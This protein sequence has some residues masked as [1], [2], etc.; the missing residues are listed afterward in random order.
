MANSH[1]YVLSERSCRAKN[2]LIKN[3][4]TGFRLHACGKEQTSHS[5]GWNQL[6]N[7]ICDI[8]QLIDHYAIANKRSP[9]NNYHDSQ[10][11]NSMLFLL[12]LLFGRIATSP[13][14]RMA[15]E[16]VKLPLCILLRFAL[17]S[18]MN[19]FILSHF[20]STTSG[21]YNDTHP[22]AQSQG[23]CLSEPGPPKDDSPNTRF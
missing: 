19:V 8:W 12:L 15:R 2:I 5:S 14:Q 7:I 1:I 13:I 6:A 22:M 4:P 9:R 18:Y 10:G 20:F 23:T 11:H 16:Y 21:E 3:C 17:K